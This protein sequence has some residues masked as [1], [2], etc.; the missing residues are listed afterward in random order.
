MILL[1]KNLKDK[2]VET[3]LKFLKNRK[4]ASLRRKK[5]KQKCA[6]LFGEKNL[7]PEEPVN[8]KKVIIEGYPSK[9]MDLGIG[10]LTKFYMYLLSNEL[11]KA[12]Q[13]ALF[14]FAFLSFFFLITEIQT[15]KLSDTRNLQL[16]PLKDT[17]GRN[18]LVTRL[19]LYMTSIQILS[20]MTYLTGRAEQLWTSTAIESEHQCLETTRKTQAWV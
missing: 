9:R 8:C 20:G 4:T 3:F 2:E 12:F 11:L 17:A 13:Q 6:L 16:L 14:L 7:F 1:L 10:S 5:K 18:I 19:I 15:R